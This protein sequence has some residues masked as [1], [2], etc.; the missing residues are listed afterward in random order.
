MKKKIFVVSLVFCLITGLTSCNQ[1]E[2]SSRSAS[3][4][5]T[6]E[7]S[8]TVTAETSSTVTEE[9][10]TA[11]SQSQNLQQPQSSELMLSEEEAKQKAF[12]HAG[13]KEEDIS[14]IKIN[15]D[16]DNGIQEYDVEFY[17][18]NKEYDY[19]INALNGNIISFDTEIENDFNKQNSNSAVNKDTDVK[20]SEQDAKKIALEKVPGAADSD[21][22]IKS[23]YDDGRL[24][25]EGEIIYQKIEYEFEID[26]SNGKII[27]WSSESV[28]D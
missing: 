22:K 14:F 9:N 27:E 12:E 24:V 7:T 25:Y 16:I 17:V 3:S 1:N 2:S 20:I 15:L 19:E 28:Y 18:G 26:A 5:E 8:S 13:V 23:D 4:N 6:V 21:I 10:K 11:D